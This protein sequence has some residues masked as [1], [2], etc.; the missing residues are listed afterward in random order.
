MNPMVLLLVGLAALGLWSGTR[1]GDDPAWGP[2]PIPAPEVYTSQSAKMLFQCPWTPVRDR[3]QCYIRL[4]K[5]Q[6]AVSG[7][8]TRD[9]DCKQPARLE[10][11][12]VEEIAR[13]DAV[14][15]KREVGGPDFGVVSDEIKATWTYDVVEYPKIKRWGVLRY[16]SHEASSQKSKI[17]GMYGSR[18]VALTE[19]QKLRN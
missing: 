18:D 5:E 17:M 7:P 16:T 12:G 9:W 14:E 11:A 19:V 8:K 1:G 2:M 13:V 3:Y 6:C 15:A 10:I 4:A